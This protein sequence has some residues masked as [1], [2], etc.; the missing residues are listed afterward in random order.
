MI[1][2]FNPM[3]NVWLHRYSKY[4]F[5]PFSVSFLVF[6]KEIHKFIPFHVKGCKYIYIPILD[7]CIW[8]GALQIQS[9]PNDRH[10]GIRHILGELWAKLKTYHKLAILLV[11]RIAVLSYTAHILYF[12]L[13]IKKFK[14]I[15]KIKK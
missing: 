9:D 11:N 8:L 12:L 5:C 6:C 15:C 4:N 10:T 1:C 13:L 3:P 7:P 2:L 14:S